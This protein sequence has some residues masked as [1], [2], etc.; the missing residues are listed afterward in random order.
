MEAE[1]D[2]PI[3]SI[4]AD[5]GEQLEL[6]YDP[7]EVSEFS[8]VMR[9]LV[10]RMGDKVAKSHEEVLFGFREIEEF[11]HRLGRST[12]EAGKIFRRFYDGLGANG[13]KLLND[14]YEH[15]RDRKLFPLALL[16]LVISEMPEGQ[17]DP[18]D[19]LLRTF[20]SKKMGGLVAK[21]STSA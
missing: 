6:G 13:I 5:R 1:S 15:Y 12:Q 10:A 9:G 18:Y 14:D 19:I 17:D 20:Y 2:N 11:A 8:V 16:T 4:D 21:Q 7:Q 3:K